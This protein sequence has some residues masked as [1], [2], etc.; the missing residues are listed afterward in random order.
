M[1]LPIQLKIGSLVHILLVDNSELTR[2][3]VG[4]VYVEDVGRLT[5]F[6]GALALWNS[7]K[8]CW[9]RGLRPLDS[10]RACGVVERQ[11][12]GVVS[13]EAGLGVVELQMR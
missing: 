11:I 4:F 9:L 1:A 13:R 2:H 8:R 10:I 3:F 7:H 6:V 12:I 5:E